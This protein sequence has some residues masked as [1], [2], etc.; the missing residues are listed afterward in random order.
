MSRGTAPDV[1]RPLPQH[2]VV[3]LRSWDPLAESIHYGSVVIPDPS[4]EIVF[5]VGAPEL[6]FYPRSTLKPLQAVGLVDSGLDLD[7]DL[8]ALAAASHS[9]ADE[10]IAGVPRILI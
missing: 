5:S 10:H 6:P 3:A 9:G 2:G 1:N 8:L 4:G 7:D